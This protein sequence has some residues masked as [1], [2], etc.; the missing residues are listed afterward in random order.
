MPKSI[1]ALAL[2][3]L[4]ASGVGATPPV[5]PL[6]SITEQTRCPVCGM[7]VG[8]YPLWLTQVRLSDGTTAAFDGVKDMAA[9][10]FAPQAFAAKEGATV[11]EIAVK[12]YYSQRWINGKSAWYVLGSDVLGPMGHELIPFADKVEA[13]TFL[14]D[15]R[16][17]RLLPHAEIS[18][19]LVE[20]LRRGHKMKHHGAKTSP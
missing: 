9:Y 20:E 3:L 6:F 16:G 8:K 15:H 13:E 14:K 7:L 18:R 2:F 4:V 12:D 5:D 10:V 19:E 17:S 11:T 1:V